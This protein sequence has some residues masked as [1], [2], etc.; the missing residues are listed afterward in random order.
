MS[1]STISL[2]NPV[3]EVQLICRANYPIQWVYNNEPQ[4]TSKIGKVP[5]ST[6][7][8]EMRKVYEAVLN[9]EPLKKEATGNYTCRK[10]FALFPQSFVYIYA[11]GDGEATFVNEGRHMQVVVRHREERVVTLPCEV[12]NPEAKPYLFIDHEDSAKIQRLDLSDQLEYDPRVGF[13]L[14]L[15]LAPDPITTFICSMSENASSFGVLITL[16]EQDT[17]EVHHDGRFYSSSTSANYGGGGSGMLVTV[18]VVLL[19]LVI[20]L[21][22]GL[23]LMYKRYQQVT[24]NSTVDAS[25][26]GNAS[27]FSSYDDVRIGSDDRENIVNHGGGVAG[28]GSNGTSMYNRFT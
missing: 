27:G 21:V 1:N 3:S 9:I 10:T 11:V 23:L 15:D 14:D 22:G 6:G 4:N 5:C 2:Y 17:N 7:S 19:I 26:L 8:E 20:L 12:S 24:L 16:R 28:G 25:Q 18:T 13:K